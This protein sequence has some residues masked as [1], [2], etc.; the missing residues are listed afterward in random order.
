MNVIFRKGASGK[1]KAYTLVSI[2]MLLLL[3]GSFEIGRYQ[4]YNDPGYGGIVVWL[5]AAIW[6]LPLLLDKHP[7]NKINQ[8]NIVLRSVCWG[9]CY[10]IFYGFTWGVIYVAAPAYYTNTF[11][12]E[13]RIERVISKKAV[14]KNRWGHVCRSIYYGQT[15]A[16]CVTHRFFESIDVGDTVRLD[17]LESQYGYFV[18]SARKLPSNQSSE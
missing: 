1:E 18:Q 11:G 7:E 12:S 9:L 16:T 6:A 17:L 4:F 5:L 10:F 15:Y 13:A 3:M 2:L 8:S 14:Y